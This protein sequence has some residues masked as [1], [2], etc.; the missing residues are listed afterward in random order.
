MLIKLMIEHA[1]LIRHEVS[2]IRGFKPPNNKSSCTE[3]CEKVST[4]LITVLEDIVSDSVVGY[5]QCCSMQ[6]F[7]SSIIS[8]LSFVFYILKTPNNVQIPDKYFN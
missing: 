3:L 2:E 5:P 8:V 7:V 6:P 4:T 1:A